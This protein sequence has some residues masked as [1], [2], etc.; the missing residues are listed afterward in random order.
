MAGTL[1]TGRRRAGPLSKGGPQRHHVCRHLGRCLEI[2]DYESAWRPRRVPTAFKNTSILPV[3]AISWVKWACCA[4]RRAR[5]RSW[6][7]MRAN[8]CRSTG[9]SSAGSSGS[10]RPR[11]SNFSTT[12]CTI[13]CDRVENLTHCIANESQVDDLTRL[14]QPQRILRYP[15]ARGQPG[16]PHG[17]AVDL[18]PHRCQF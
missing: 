1:R 4:P 15:G 9:T 16:R 13:L 12:C 17:P 11:P 14:M 3:R 2:I 10:I 6:P 8:C 5:P 18:V 7:R